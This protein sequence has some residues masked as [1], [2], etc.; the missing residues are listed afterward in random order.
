VARRSAL[1]AFLALV[2]AL[3]LAAPAMAAETL[4]IAPAGCN[5]VTVTGA[6]LPAG[7]KLT[8]VVSDGFSGKALKQ[9]AATS[10]TDG[11]VKATVA[12]SLRGLAAVGA[13]VR[14]GDRILLGATHNLEAALRAQCGGGAAAAGNGSLPFTG[15]AQAYAMLAIGAGLLCLGG[16]VRASF[17]YRGRH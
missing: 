3:L 8:V 13:E 4:T 15:P 2:V 5:Q 7:M 11:S 6:G 14:Q 10:A 16:L 1:L 12:V 17:A 9:V